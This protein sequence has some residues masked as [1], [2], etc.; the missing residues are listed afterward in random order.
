MIILFC[1]LKQCEQVYLN[2]IMLFGSRANPIKCVFKIQQMLF[3]TLI[4][5]IKILVCLFL[6]DLLDPPQEAHICLQTKMSPSAVTMSLLGVCCVPDSL[7][8]L[9]LS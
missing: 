5:R 2:I 6:A 4:T 3:Q 1:G 8:D 7:C 9:P